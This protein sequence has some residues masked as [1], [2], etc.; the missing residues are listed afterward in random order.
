M[1]RLAWIRR[2]IRKLGPDEVAVYEGEVDIHLNPK[3]GPDWMLSG[4]QK[5]VL[6]PS[7]NQ[8]RYL[9]RAVDARTCK[10]TWIEE[11]R[12]N[13][14]LFLLLIHRLVAVSNRKARWIYIIPDKFKIQDS[15]QVQMALAL[16]TANCDSTF[17]HSIS[18]DLKMFHSW[19][20]K[21]WTGASGGVYA[22]ISIRPT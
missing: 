6:T 14:S 1:R 5:G 13:S 9:A 18:S 19:P 7:Q 4:Q 17:C 8:E 3:I 15:R 10:R 12:E 21:A 16:G 20:R 2:L 22:V 11:E